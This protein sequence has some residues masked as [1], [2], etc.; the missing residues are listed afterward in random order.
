MNAANRSLA[1][2]LALV[3]IMGWVG[4]QNPQSIHSDGFVAIFGQD[5]PA[6]RSEYVLRKVRFGDSL[7]TVAGQE[8]GDPVYR[9][10]FGLSYEMS[11]ADG[12]Q[13]TLSYF[14]HPVDQNGVASIL[15]EAYMP[16]EFSSIN[17]YREIEEYLNLSYGPPRGLQ[18]NYSWES[19]DWNTRVYLQ[20][21][22][23]KRR[24]SLNFLSLSGLNPPLEIPSTSP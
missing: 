17:L 24:L 12:P 1:L 4:C 9:D 16:D 19:E 18:G 20:L 11:V 22:E 10:E 14:Q 13:I 6:K 8:K 3:A 21:A 15:V 7:V 5:A 23:T 2:W